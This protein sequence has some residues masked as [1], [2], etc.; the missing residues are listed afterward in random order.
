MVCRAPRSLGALPVE[1]RE[2]REV[3]IVL[4]KAVFPCADWN[5][6]PGAFESTSNVF[7]LPIGV[8][9]DLWVK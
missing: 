2:G 6:T 5:L 9:I 8:S 1:E 7:F 4:A 3:A